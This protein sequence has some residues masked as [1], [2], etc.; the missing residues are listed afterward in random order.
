MVHDILNMLANIFEA[1]VENGI[2]FLASLYESGLG[3][4]AINTARSTL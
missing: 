2:K 3:Y 1:S 4:S